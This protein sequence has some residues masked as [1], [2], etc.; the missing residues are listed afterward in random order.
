MSRHDTSHGTSH[1]AAISTSRRTPTSDLM[2][3]L[4]TPLHGDSTWDFK[5]VRQDTRTIRRL[6]ADRA[7]GAKCYLVQAD[8]A[9]AVLRPCGPKPNAMKVAHCPSSAAKNASHN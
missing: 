4:M 2:I 3:Y 5:A 1:G 6:L 9:F 8:R 7:T